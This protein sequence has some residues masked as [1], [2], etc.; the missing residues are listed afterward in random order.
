MSALIGLA[1]LGLCVAV[2]VI[3]VRRLGVPGPTWPLSVV[4][5]ASLF[6]LPLQLLGLL[7]LYLDASMLSLGSA[8][9]LQCAFAAMFAVVLWLQRGGRRSF[10]GASNEPD[11]PVSS[12]SLGASLTLLVGLG[13]LLGMGYPR[14]FEVHA[15][16]LPIALSIFKRAP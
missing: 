15:Y 6:Y 8:L 5:G 14:G 12:R 13:V 4:F 1:Y 16:H 10:V 7:G 3:L 2:P 9:S 11:L